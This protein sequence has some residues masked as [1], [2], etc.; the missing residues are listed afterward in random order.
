M[1]CTSL[2]HSFLVGGALCVALLS[3]C[4][5]DSSSAS[6]PAT[7][8]VKDTAKAASDSTKAPAK[9]TMAKAGDAVNKVSD[10]A[11]KA[12]DAVS[13]PAAD[14]QAM[15]A[16]IKTQEELDAAAAK[17]ITDANADAEFEKLMKD[18]DKDDGGN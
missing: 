13:K 4:G 1:N 2:K 6:P 3:G 15:I 7:S 9:D 5:D 18:I 12:A 10:T 14:A 17:D 8:S 16:K 11:T